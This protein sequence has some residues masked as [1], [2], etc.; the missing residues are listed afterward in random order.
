MSHSQ[1]ELSHLECGHNQL[2]SLDISNN[3]NIGKGYENSGIIC[4]VIN[5]M[6]GL[7][8]VCVWT[9]P[10]PPAGLLVSVTGSPNVY[11]TTQCSE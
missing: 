9:V 10:F 4:L 8:E 5:Y 7:R 1:H 6:A 3:P 2:T 11:Y